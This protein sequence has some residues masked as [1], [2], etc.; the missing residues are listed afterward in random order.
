MNLIAH[1][2]IPVADLDRAMRFYA[3]VFDVRFGDVVTV[4]GSRMA[5]FPFQEGSD[6]ASGALAQ[7]EVYVPT[8]NG[9]IVYFSVA[10]IEPVLEKAVI[11]GGKVLFPKT[12]VDAVQ[13]VAEI[14]DSEGNRIAI[15]SA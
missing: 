7:G 1:V 3:L 11:Q 4:H 10:D 9:A 13:F 15:L 14:E 2:E 6:G 5:H 12:P 8:K